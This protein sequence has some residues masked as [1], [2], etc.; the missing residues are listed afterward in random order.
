MIS[1]SVLEAKRDLGTKVHMATE[2][3]DAGILNEG[4]LDDELK[5]YFEGWKRFSNDMQFKSVEMPEFKVYSSVHGY[6]GMIDRVGTING[7]LAILDIKTTVVIYPSVAIQL[8]AYEKAYLD[9][10]AQKLKNLKRVA[11]Q[12]KKDGSYKL[13]EFKDP[14]DFNIFFYGLQLK[15]W[16]TKNLKEA[17]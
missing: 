11:I 14:N 8:A 16:R 7:K 3:Y 13:H 10:T 1:Q 17:I 4:T 12:L 15:N 5:P 9:Y 2:Y 6:A